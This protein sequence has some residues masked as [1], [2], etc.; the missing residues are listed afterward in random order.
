M[1]WDA[2]PQEVA[3]RMAESGPKGSSQNPFP[4]RKPSLTGSREFVG[5]WREV[6]ERGNT[7]VPHSQ[8]SLV[9]IAYLAKAA[10][11]AASPMPFVVS[12][13]GGLFVPAAPP[14]LNYPAQAC[15]CAGAGAPEARVGER[16]ARACAASAS[17]SERPKG[18]AG[19]PG[20]SCG[21]PGP[22]SNICQVQDCAR[23]RSEPCHP[24]E[25]V[26]FSALRPEAA[27]GLGVPHPELPETMT[28][29][30][31]RL[32]RKNSLR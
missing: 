10:P 30:S 12:L 27:R 2:L 11:G 5:G 18:H 28:T 31:Q 15:G 16:T 32:S 3:Q 1:S 14:A 26:C 21:P 25:L 13:C 7:W 29:C 4:Q 8:W 24:T 17:T 6:P 20:F 9:P 23:S 19:S 22:P